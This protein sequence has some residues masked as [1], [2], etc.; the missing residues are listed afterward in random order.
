MNSQANLCHGN[1]LPERLPTV[2]RA[3]WRAQSDKK[4]KVLSASIQ[5]T[6]PGVHARGSQTKLSHIGAVVFNTRQRP[7]RFSCP[8]PAPSLHSARQG[9]ESWRLFLA[10]VFSKL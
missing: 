1:E 2:E 6:P 10:W 8:L 5:R 3:R 7:D 9:F 4:R